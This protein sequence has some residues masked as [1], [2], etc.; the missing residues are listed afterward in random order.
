MHV[1]TPDAAANISAVSF[2]F[3]LAT[4]TSS[5]YDV[6]HASGIEAAYTKS[7]ESGTLITWS[8]CTFANLLR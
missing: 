3:I 8:L 1:P 7:R 5:W 2:F 6:I 4:L